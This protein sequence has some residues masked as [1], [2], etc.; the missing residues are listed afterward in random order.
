MTKLT[1]LLSE[2]FDEQPKVDKHKV[3]E[4]VKGYGKIGQS[5]FNNNNIME[6]AKQLSEIAE[7]AH[8]HILGEQGD[9]F[10]KVSVNKNMGVLK[11][12]VKEF[13]K[14]AIESHQLNQRL[15]GLYEDMGNILGRYYEIDEHVMQE[16]TATGVEPDYAPGHGPD[17]KD[18][19]GDG[20]VEPDSEE[21]L[22]LKDKAIQANMGEG[23]MNELGKAMA[24]LV[25]PKKLPY[26]QAM[27]GAGLGHDLATGGGASDAISGLTGKEAAAQGAQLGAELAQNMTPEMKDKI[28]QK[29]GD[30]TVNLPQIQSGEWNV[31]DIVKGISDY[32]DRLGLTPEM[33]DKMEKERYGEGKLDTQQESADARMLR[34]AGITKEAVEAN[35]PTKRLKD[36]KGAGIVTPGA[37]GK[38][39]KKW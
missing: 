12:S 39:G 7:N 4:G 6:V 18:W 13:K 15:Q 20:L 24:S 32:K 2:V 36:I 1:N 3:I 37:V 19:D 26:M 22:Q 14:T 21:Y 17:D 38:I 33:I 16:D 31:T 27:H 11:N 34:L 10:D 29:I 25:P 8:S 30:M 9:W 5:L 28:K 23:E 35:R